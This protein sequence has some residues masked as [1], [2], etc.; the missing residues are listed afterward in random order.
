MSQ[1]LYSPE[2]RFWDMLVISG[3]TQH[4]FFN[5]CLCGFADVSSVIE[6]SFT[7]E[8]LVLDLAPEV[9]VLEQL[10]PLSPCH[11]LLH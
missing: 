7:F 3:Y 8:V 1:N 4:L 6:E 9:L 11:L 5:A 2:Y 10:M